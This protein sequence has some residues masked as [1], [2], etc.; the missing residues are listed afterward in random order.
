[1]I[2]IVNKH[3]KIYIFSF[4]NVFL[5]LIKIMEHS[6]FKKLVKLATTK[7]GCILLQ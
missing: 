7:L 1:M 5:I 2:S 4:K 6:Q 3:T